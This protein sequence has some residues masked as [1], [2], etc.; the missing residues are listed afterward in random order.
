MI[1][2]KDAYDRFRKTPAT[3]KVGNTNVIKRFGG[4]L[5]EDD[6]PIYGISHE[7]FHI[8]KIWLPDCARSGLNVL[9]TGEPGVGKGLIAKEIHAFAQVHEKREIPFV[10]VNCSAFA[11]GDVDGILFGDNEKS[12]YN[13][14]KGGFL[15]LDEISLLDSHLLGKLSRRLECADICERD[16]S[17]RTRIVATTNS[18]EKIRK[19]LFW[20]FHERIDIPPLAK[21][22]LDI[23]FIINGLLNNHPLLKRGK[24]SEWLFTP[25]TILN[26][27]FSKW[28]GN[29]GGLKNAIDIAAA[30]YS[31]A[32]KGMPKF[33][34]CRNIGTGVDVLNLQSSR[35]DLWRNLS[36]VVRSDSRG[37]QLIPVEPLI[38]SEVKNFSAL[39]NFGEDK[40]VPCLN[41]AEALEFATIC[42]EHIINDLRPSED[43]ESR[44]Y[45]LETAALP[46]P[47]IMRWKYDENGN[48]RQE[49]TNRG[50]DFSGMTAEMAYGAYLSA[51]R[52]R[53]PTI[54]MACKISGISK[55]TI[56][57]DLK[58][59]NIRQYK[60]E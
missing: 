27:L 7:I 38:R 41:C 10:K 58:Q 40:D 18:P 4:I 23:F 57:K 49:G 13:K 39:K 12:F 34:T 26:I 16:N 51:L 20:R 17:L 24:A 47:K 6:G 21:R 45:M 31:D 25:A 3:D 55:T 42:Y 30:R 46:L 60:E 56:E 32:P 44:L 19:D 37:K 2:L 22:R 43:A 15:F 14:V 11:D 29:V 35:Y 48:I 28:D 52:D 54:T 53:C 33:F 8:K 59:H 36:I 1:T 50:I 9:V 5:N